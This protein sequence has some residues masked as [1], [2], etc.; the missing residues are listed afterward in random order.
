MVKA[1]EIEKLMKEQ[2][3]PEFKWMT[4]KDIEIAR[5][6]RMK[7]LFGCPNYGTRGTCPPNVPSIEESRELFREYERIA[8]IRISADAGKIKDHKKWSRDTNRKLLELEKSAFKA[9]YSKAFVLYVDGNCVCEECSGSRQECTNKAAARPSPESLGVDVF[10]TVKKCG[11]PLEVLAE[12]SGEM[13]RY[14]FLL[15]S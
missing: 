11:F 9:G 3:Y 7:C 12:H 10:S 2:G 8:I 13:N 6:V 5:W 15:V 1:K 14:S 4:G